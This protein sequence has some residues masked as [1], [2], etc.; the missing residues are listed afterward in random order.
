M[1]MVSAAQWIGDFEAEHGPIEHCQAQPL[2]SQGHQAQPLSS[3][4]DQAQPLTS[5]GH[6]AQLHD[7]QAQ[8]WGFPAEPFAAVMQPV[9][10]VTQP[11]G[12]PQ[13]APLGCQTQP[14]AT[15]TQPMGIQ[16]GGN[17]TAWH[18][19]LSVKVTNGS[20]Q[21]DTP[22]QADAK[23]IIDRFITNNTPSGKPPVPTEHQHMHQD[24]ARLVATLFW[25]C[26]IGCVLM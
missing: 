15:K 6:Q 12:Y 2:T 8:S 1:N 18:E 11:S 4:G 23:L 14:L 10:T 21:P 5:Q 17:S 19:T 25:K 26:R 20:L 3:Q 16:A 9:H 7:I 22:E 24:A 13:I